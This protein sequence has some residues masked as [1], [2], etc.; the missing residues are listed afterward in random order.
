MEKFTDRLLFRAKKFFLLIFVGLMF[1]FSY[2]SIRPAFS[3]TEKVYVLDGSRLPLGDGKLSSGPMQGYVYACQTH[4]HGGGAQHVGNWIHAD[5]WDS[6]QKIAVQGDVSRPEAVF[7]IDTANGTRQVIGNALPVGHTTGIFP[8]QNTDPAFTIDRNPN[9]IV[10]QNIS[11]SLSLYP[12][13]ASASS[14][15]PMGIIGVMLDGVPLFNALDAGGRDAVAHEVQDHCN[16]HPERSGEYHYHGPSPCVKAETDNNSLIGYALDG[17]GITSMFDENGREITNADLDECHGRV[18]PILWDGK[19]VTIY[20]YV[21]TREYPYTIGCFR[22][23]PLTPRH[24]SREMPMELSQPVMG[25]PSVRN[26]PRQPPPEAV[27]ACAG[28]A[29]GD[30]CG[31][32]TLRGDI[33]NGVCRA[34][35]DVLACIPSR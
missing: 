25:N 18:S 3:E 10:P 6:T 29:F 13:L 26:G 34:P 27:Q 31:F 23:T 7:R 24:A 30:S 16:G 33:I 17:F 5:T 22:G 2:M 4:F 1:V 8:V 19:K 14:C 21:M 35:I 20:H 11:Y 9:S 32:T 15:V 28:L 12:S